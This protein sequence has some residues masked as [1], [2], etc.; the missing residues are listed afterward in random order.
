VM[1]RPDLVAQ[2]D[3]VMLYFETHDHRAC[4]IFPL[5]D[6]MVLL[7]TTDLRVASPYDNLCTDAEIDYLFHVLSDVLPEA[8]P[9]RD[10][11]RFAY[12]GVRPLPLSSDD[13]TGAISRDHTFR[14]FEATPERPFPVVTLI[15]GKWTTYRSCAEQL[16]DRVLPLI[17][18]RRTSTTA[19]VTIGGGREFPR[20]EGGRRALVADVA[21]AG[22]LA[23]DAAERLVARY[24][25]TARAIA[26]DLAF[27]G[28]RGLA[29]APAYL[30][31]EI[32]WIARN[33]RV[34]T[35][36]DVMLRRTLMAF[37]GWTS[38][39]TM[40]DCAGIVA[41]VLGWSEA[42]QQEEIAAT[43][44]MLTTRHRVTVERNAEE[45]HAAASARA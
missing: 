18:A 22:G 2:L 31:G 28:R 42:R 45:R 27:A 13:A 41:S 19:S 4:L 16:V 25:T 30:A 40:R 34:T 7:G 29:G 21:A 12:S 5:D 44:H 1:E 39:A 10:Q 14:T 3:G 8:R 26:G 15:G 38:R 17:G 35:L 33:E 36:E 24:G 32:S 43:I 20:S 37:E 9:A 11:I 6:R 23:A